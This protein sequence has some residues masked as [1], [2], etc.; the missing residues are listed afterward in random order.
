[1]SHPCAIPDC[2]RPAK[3]GQLMCWPHWKRVPRAINWA[4]FKNYENMCRRI[5]GAREAYREAR[6]A[7]ISA[8]VAKEH[9]WEYD[10]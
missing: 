8:V 2:D 5:P 10:L 1:M 9:E 6:D 4:V 3:D 7:A